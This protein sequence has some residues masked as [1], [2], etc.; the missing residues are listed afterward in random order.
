MVEPKTPLTARRKQR[1]PHTKL[2][3]HIISRRGFD[4]GG[5]VVCEKN[6][7]KIFLKFAKMDVYPRLVCRGDKRG[8]KKE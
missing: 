6:F 1:T 4:R 7:I 3:P 8:R 5:F 2:R